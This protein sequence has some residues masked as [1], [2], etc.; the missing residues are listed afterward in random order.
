MYNTVSCEIRIAI[1]F[2]FQAKIMS[3]A[4]IRHELSDLEIKYGE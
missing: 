3:S 4:E 1:H 2:Y